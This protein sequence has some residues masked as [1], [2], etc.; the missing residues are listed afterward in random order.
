MLDNVPD[1]YKRFP[2]VPT[3][4]KPSHAPLHLLAIALLYTFQAQYLGSLNNEIRNESCM[5][6]HR[7]SV[8]AHRSIP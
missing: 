5:I 6:K 8:L 7:W 1:L 3:A 4:V 2:F